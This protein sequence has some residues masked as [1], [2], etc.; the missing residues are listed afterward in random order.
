MKPQTGVG[1]RPK[2]NAPNGPAVRRG[3]LYLLG[4]KAMDLLYKCAVVFERLIKYQYRF[5]LGRKGKL[6]EIVLGF[7]ETDFH[8]LVGLH[9]LKDINIA[10]DNRK[11][12]F[13][14]ILSRSI[15]DQTIAKSAFFNESRL[16]LEAFQFL[17]D[18]LD[19]EQLVFRFNKKV[20]PYS[21][22]DGDFLL[23]MGDGLALS[24]SFLFIDKEDCGVYFC[25]SF[26]PMER[27]DYTK[28]QMQYTPLKKEKINVATGETIVQYDRL[29]PRNKNRAEN[30]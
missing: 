7:N 8:H 11:R 22:I 3:F 13:H 16:R 28:N 10:R 20:V 29:T 14:N 23:K 12:V 15:T 26:F 30:D 4:E 2:E 25:R 18:L 27:T 9:K 5:I 17:E 1:E 24:V 21:A 6:I 19:G